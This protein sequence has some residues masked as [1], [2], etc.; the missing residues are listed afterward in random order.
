MCTANY[1][2]T[3]TFFLVLTVVGYLLTPSYKCA[4]KVQ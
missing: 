1:E 3:V 2:R 4:R